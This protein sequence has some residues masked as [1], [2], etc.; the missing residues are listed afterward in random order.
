MKILSAEMATIPKQ[1][2]KKLLKKHFGLKMTEEAAEALARI[3]E[4]RAKKISKFAVKN[5]KKEKRDRVT[6]KD[7]EEF[8]LREGFGED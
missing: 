2:V 6:K 4:K 5:A 8:V 7:I 1:S 3:L